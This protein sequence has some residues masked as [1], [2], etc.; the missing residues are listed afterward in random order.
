MKFRC[1]NKKGKSYHNYGGRGIKV[2]DRWLEKKTGFSNFLQDMG[3]KP[4][5]KHSLDRFPDNNDDYK[6]S[7]CR[8]ATPKEQNGNSRKNHWESNNGEKL[9]ISE[10]ARKLGMSVPTIHRHLSTKIMDEIILYY[11]NKPYGK[12][13]FT[14]VQ[15]FGI[16][17]RI[18][19]GESKRRL[20]EELQ[21]SYRTICDIVNYKTYK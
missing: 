10:W 18:K 2:C 3:L 9:I 21:V 20:A 17:N 13:M 4:S 6:P 15:V 19:N 8:W 12:K 1:Y 11:K 7:N 5:K 16:R 14:Y